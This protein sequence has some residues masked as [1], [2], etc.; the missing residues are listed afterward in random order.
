[1]NKGRLIVVMLVAVVLAGAAWA[2]DKD[3][4]KGVCAMCGMMKMC[5]QAC[6]NV[7]PTLMKQRDMINSAVLSKDDPC[8]L[9]G[10]KDSLKLSEKQVKELEKISKKSCDSAAKVLTKEQKDMLADVP[11]GPMCMSSVQGAIQKEAMAAMMKHME[12]KTKEGAPPARGEGKKEDRKMKK[13]EGPEK[14]EMKKEMKEE[15]KMQ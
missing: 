10:M 9:L 15:K 2:Q 3:A 5:G 7:S 11:S 8:I 13:G 14:K 6:A 4:P 1:M 12:S